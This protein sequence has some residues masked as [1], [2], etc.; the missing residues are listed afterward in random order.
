MKKLLLILIFIFSISPV[1]AR[2]VGLLEYKDYATYIETN[3]LRYRGKLVSYW[4][5]YD[6]SSLQTNGVFSQ[7]IKW[8]NNCETEEHRILSIVVYSEKMGAGNVLPT[9]PI[10]NDRWDHIVPGSAGEFMHK[11]VCSQ[12]I[13]KKY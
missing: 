4:S 13:K 2:W 3:S 8:E 7:K 6:Y 10:E 5:M 9:T 1:Q 12:D 11:Y